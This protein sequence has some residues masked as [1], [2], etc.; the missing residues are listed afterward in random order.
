VA[1]QIITH[2][3]D[4][5]DGTEAEET[6]HFALDGVGYEI[7]LNAKNATELRRFL[8][9]FQD[10]GTRTGKISYGQ[11][12]QVSRYSTTKVQTG[13]NREQN[14]KIRTWAAANG[15][16]LAERGRNPQHIVDAYES[17]TPN[18]EWVTSQA[19]AKK[20]ADE[21]AGKSRPRKT[22]AKAAP[23]IQLVVAL[24]LVPAV[25]LLVAAA[26]IPALV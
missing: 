23:K 20:V 8:S 17:K 2:L 11:H 12:A 14:Q 25:L 1:K 10:A 6:V 15:W 9:K 22:A 4:D 24:L 18:P 3:V 16:E 13:L 21:V 26:L 19:A 5:L 7:D